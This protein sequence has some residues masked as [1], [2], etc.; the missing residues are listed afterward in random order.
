MSKLS[1][2][3]VTTPEQQLTPTPENTQCAGEPG[4]APEPQSEVETKVPQDAEPTGEVA[5]QVEKGEVLE[6][7]LEE[8][9]QAEANLKE[10]RDKFGLDHPETLEACLRMLDSWIGLYKLR[11]MD[12]LLNEVIPIAKA[13]YPDLYPRFIQSQAFLRFKQFRFKESLSLF[14]VRRP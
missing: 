2:Q 10:K 3:E 14:K 9:R 1:Q 12:E 11:P 8:E 5:E 4:V 7:I 6:E 13:K